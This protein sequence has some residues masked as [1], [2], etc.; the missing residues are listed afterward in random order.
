MFIV[1]DGSGAV[2]GAVTGESLATLAQAKPTEMIGDIV[3]RNYV[4]VSPD[5]SVWNV[6][7]AMRSTDSAFALIAS[8]D[9]DLSAANVQGIITRKDILDVLADDM[10]LFGV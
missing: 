4:I 2:A 9:N 1:T 6:V 10:E 7:V 5:D 3:R 8:H